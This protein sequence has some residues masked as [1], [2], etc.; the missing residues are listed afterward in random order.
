[1]KINKDIQIGDTG[2]SLEKLIPYVLYSNENGIQGNFTLNDNIDN[3]K[4]IDI[5]VKHW[6]FDIYK[7][8]TLHDLTKTHT[9]D[10]LVGDGGCLYWVASRIS[11]SNK[12][13]NIGQSYAMNTYA[14][15]TS[16][17]LATAFASQPSDNNVRFKIY[18]VIGYK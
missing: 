16:S 1:M 5:L 3:Y 15:R 14:F 11:I 12:N 4:K 6:Y 8:F 18:K 2:Y 13:V 10:M 17:S 9:L 7:T